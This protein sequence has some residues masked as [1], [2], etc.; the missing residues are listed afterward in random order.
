ML[1]LYHNDMS[2]CAA[3]VRTALAEKKAEWTGV[4]LDLRAGDAQKPEYLKL[5]PMAVVPT[6]VVDGVPIIEST[7]ICEYVDD[8]FPDAPLK[9][10]DALGRARMRLWTKQLDDTLHAAVGTLSFCIAFRHQWLARPAED[11]ARWLAGIPQ[12]E[13]RD[14]S[15][16]NLEHGLQ[17]SYFRPALMRYLKLFGDIEAALADRPWLAGDSFSLADV[18]YAPYLARLRHLGCD[19]LFDRHPRV[20]AWAERVAA[21][22][23]VQEGVARWFN[24]KYLALFEQQRGPARETIA[25]LLA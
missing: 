12:P 15:Q 11:R 20:A 13:R 1:T 25:K 3:K 21:R 24:P 9:P 7:V 17:S 2:V 6:L 14:R 16:Q 10:A 23:S 19:V 4:V 18:G 5:N 22:P 8:R